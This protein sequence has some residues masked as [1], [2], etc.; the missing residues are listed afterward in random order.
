MAI[1][2][3][4]RKPKAV[5][6][7]R[8]WFIGSGLASLAGAA[9]LIRDAQMSGERITILGQQ[10]VSGGHLTRRK[11]QKKALNSTEI[12]VLLRENQLIN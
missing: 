10:Q 1:T 4:S 6:G 12:G 5:D 7:K 3:H 9:F 2:K 11:S 8:A